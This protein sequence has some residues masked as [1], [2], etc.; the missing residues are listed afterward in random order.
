MTKLTDNSFV[1][2]LTESFKSVK[3]FDSDAGE[4][5]DKKRKAKL[6]VKNSGSV[7]GGNSREGIDGPSPLGSI[8]D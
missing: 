4:V 6:K 3:D 1:R 7:S 5:M 8:K 2:K